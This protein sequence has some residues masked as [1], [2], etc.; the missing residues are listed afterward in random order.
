MDGLIP[1]SSLAQEVVT[2]WS[3]QTRTQTPIKQGDFIGI[4]PRV[5]HGHSALLLRL[6]GISG[7]GASRGVT[8]SVGEQ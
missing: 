3:G 5:T 4:L 2:N 6:W 7:D 8:M 1:V